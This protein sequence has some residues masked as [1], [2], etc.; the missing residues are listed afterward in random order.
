MTFFL[1]RN[2]SDALFGD[3][4]P[5]MVCVCV[6][7]CVMFFPLLLFYPDFVTLL[8][9]PSSFLFPSSSLPVATG[10]SFLLNLL[11]LF[12][13]GND[14]T[15]PLC[16]PNYASQNQPPQRVSHRNRSIILQL[17][18]SGK[19]SAA[20][21]R[22]VLRLAATPALRPLVAAWTSRGARGLP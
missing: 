11:L 20:C 3:G 2:F 16:N 21:C 10:N 5:S 19:H 6:C 13:R 1:Q 7:V 18:R 15:S 4:K 22:Y 12:G 14:V 8:D 9:S 17:R